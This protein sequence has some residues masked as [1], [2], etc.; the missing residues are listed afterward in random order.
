MKQVTS[1]LLQYRFA[2][3]SYHRRL[4]YI[5]RRQC[6]T[7]NIAHWLNIS[8]ISKYIYRSLF[9]TDPAEVFGKTTLRSNSQQ[10]VNSVSSCW[11]LFYCKSYSF[12]KK[13]NANCLHSKKNQVFT[14]PP[15]KVPEMSKSV[16]RCP[17]SQKN[18]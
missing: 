10:S 18:D 13:R 4:I 8:N 16:Q 11:E 12:S 9:N 14:E 1:C 2:L 5:D 6:S 3:S 15:K 7:T 17:K